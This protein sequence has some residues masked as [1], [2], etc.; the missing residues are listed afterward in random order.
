MLTEVRSF[1]VSKAKQPLEFFHVH[2]I[3][4]LLY[5]KW[6]KILLERP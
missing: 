6:M 5:S 3:A 1:L 2:A 4:T